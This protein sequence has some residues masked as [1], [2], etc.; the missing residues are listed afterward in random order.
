MRGWERELNVMA[1]LFSLSLS[2][3]PTPHW[4]R[5]KVRNTNSSQ[6]LR[7]AN[8]CARCFFSYDDLVMKIKSVKLPCL[9]NCICKR[10]KSVNTEA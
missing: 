10:L 5:K 1:S 2:R 3:Q 6:S 9:M 4:N 7:E 8:I